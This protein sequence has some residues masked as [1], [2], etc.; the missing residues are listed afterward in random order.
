M[1]GSPWS[2]VF[3]RLGARVCGVL[4][5]M[6]VVPLCWGFVFIY[7]IVL[8]LFIGCPCLL[9]YFGWVG[10]GFL[11]PGGVVELFL[12]GGGAGLF[13]LVGEFLVGGRVLWGVF[14]GVC[15]A[16]GCGVCFWVSV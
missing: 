2:G 15:V 3:V 4:W 13:G 9:G 16:C 5:G 10:G 12:Y 1:F 14:L 6:V 11:C 7:E 8:S